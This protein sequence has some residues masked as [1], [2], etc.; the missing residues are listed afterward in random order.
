MAQRIAL[1]HEETRGRLQDLDGPLQFS[2]LPLELADGSEGPA[3]LRE[4]A[5]ET[6]VV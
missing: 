2:V 5:A 1:P 6:S 4:I 3:N